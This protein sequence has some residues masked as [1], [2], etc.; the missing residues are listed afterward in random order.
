M[1]R[2]IEKKGGGKKIWGISMHQNN[3]KMSFSVIFNK[4]EIHALRGLLEQ[5]FI[6]M[7][8]SLDFTP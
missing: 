2:K 3:F 6:N 8:A 5:I 4:E 1:F 7:S